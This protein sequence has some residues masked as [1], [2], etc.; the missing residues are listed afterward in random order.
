MIF[1]FINVI[2]SIDA[3][4]SGVFFKLTAGLKE[5]EVTYKKQL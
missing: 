2:S 3:K 4:A 5:I 1:V